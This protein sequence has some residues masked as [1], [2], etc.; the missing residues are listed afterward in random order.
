MTHAFDQMEN[1]IFKVCQDRLKLDL[2]LPGMRTQFAREKE[3]VRAHII[4]TYNVQRPVS[5]P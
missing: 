4:K 3:R 2:E 1:V 5:Q